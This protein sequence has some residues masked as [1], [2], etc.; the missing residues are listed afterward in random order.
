MA[1][2]AYDPLGLLPAGVYDCTLA[3][4]ATVLCWNDHRRRLWDDLLRFIEHEYRP[5][6]VKAPLWI[7]GSF[8]RRKELPPDVDVVLDFSGE[9]DG[10]P[11]CMQLRL[12]HATIKREYR[13]DLWPRHPLLPHDL[14]EF[15][16][17]AGD[18]CAVELNIPPKTPKGILR[19][20][21]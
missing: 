6:K 20:V 16:Q 17:Y 3:E 9:N 1:I 13:V 11:K 7:D 2:P 19:V 5:L 21:P 12:K 10:L 15:F 18:K 8:V 14:A 4:A